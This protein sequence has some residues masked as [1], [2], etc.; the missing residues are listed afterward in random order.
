MH[1]TGIIKELKHEIERLRHEYESEKILRRFWQEECTALKEQC[2]SRF[3]RTIRP[4]SV[5]LRRKHIN[6]NT[7][8]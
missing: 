3:Y 8:L 6:N 2:N 4:P 1:E 7:L 5:H